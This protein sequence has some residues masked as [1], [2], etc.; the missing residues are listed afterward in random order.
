LQQE[1]TNQEL[2]ALKT[3]LN[4]K[5]TIPT[6][7][8]TPEETKKPTAAD[9]TQLRKDIKQL[10]TEDKLATAETKANDWLKTNPDDV[11]VRL[12]LGLIEIQEK[13]FKSAQNNL[14]NVLAHDPAYLDARIGLIKIN[15]E[16]KNYTSAQDLIDKGLKISPHQPMLLDYQKRILYLKTA[17]GPPSSVKVHKFNDK[18][19]SHVMRAHE[20]LLFE[21]KKNLEQRNFSKAKA[22]S[23]Y[24]LEKNP[25]DV[26]VRIKLAEIYVAQYRDIKALRVIKQGLIFEPNNIKL[27]NK[28]GEVRLVLHFYAL[29]AESFKQVLR[30]D[31]NNKTAKGYLSEINQITPFYT[32]GLNEIG[33][34]T[35]NAYV[36]DLHSVWDFSSLYY[37]RDTDLGPITAQLNYASRM[38][39]TA[40]QFAINF[41]PQI[42]RSIYLDLTAAFAN[43]LELFPRTMV[44]A[45]AFIDIPK[46][47]EFSGG[48]KYSNIDRT[49]F[50]TYTGS[51]NW[52]PGSYWIAFRPYVFE[53]KGNN[54]TVLYTAT[55]RRYFATQDHFIS[56][57]GGS[58]RSPDLADLLT[59]NFIIIKNNFINGNYEFPILNHHVV[60]NLG[61]G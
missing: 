3:S 15:I 41:L 13:D 34:L 38:H 17:K 5:T 54:D 37:K 9:S 50:A 12:L 26:E 47:L 27:L 23:Q 48:V 60:V 33:I 52:Y 24:W 31:P 30:L 35:D 44:A 55:I 36:A 45:E 8:V 2:T 46:L 61:A 21:I 57:T 4:D 53:P 7:K 18:Q 14:E 51:L 19:V 22:L 16:S 11:D 59:V 20:R 1:P 28:E 40:P 25:R 32:Y 39:E 6:T 29:A 43:K 58:G 42:N 49:Y 56:L 10:I